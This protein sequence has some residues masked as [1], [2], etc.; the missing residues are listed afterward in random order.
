MDYFNYKSSPIDWCERNYEVVSSIAE[1]YNTVSQ[2]SLIK[3]CSIEFSNHII[4]K[5]IQCSLFYN[6]TNFN[7]SISRIWQS[8]DKRCSLNFCNAYA[9][10]CRLCLFPFHFELGK[11][12]QVE[13]QKIFKVVKV[14]ILKAGQLMDE[15]FILWVLLGSYAM[16]FPNQYLPGHFQRNR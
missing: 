6:T 1:F 14:L 4:F 16:L 11:L 13:F 5:G 8:C 12:K 10:R 7:L 9:S 15:L 2:T 3:S